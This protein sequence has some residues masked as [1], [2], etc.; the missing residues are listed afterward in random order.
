[1]NKT[2]QLD[3]KTLKEI[4]AG[5]LTNLK[6]HSKEVD[7]L[8]VFPVPDGDTGNNMSMT[9]Q[10]GINAIQDSSIVEV[11]AF[12]RSFSRGTLLG[13][14][15]NSGVILSQFMKGMM[16]GF[17]ACSMV[18]IPV[19]QKAFRMGVEKAY[20]AVINPT[21]G[22]MLTVMR[23]GCDALDEYL[24]E[25]E[26]PCFEDVF[27]K[28]NAAMEISLENTPNL[29]PV[30]KEA[31]VIDSGGAG[32]LYIFK[33]M[34]KVLK[35]EPLTF[36]DALHASGPEGHVINFSA[37]HADSVLEYG[38]CTEFILQL[39]NS[40]VD[41]RSF[42][43]KVIVDFL[44]Q[45]GDSIVAVQDEDIIKIHVHTFRPGDVLNFCQQ[46]GEF[47]TLKIENMS[48][49]HN[50]IMLK[51]EEKTTE[52]TKE[53]IKKPIAIV[54]AVS[55]SGLQ[56][57]FREIGADV[58]VDGGQTDNP[59]TEDFLEAFEQIESKTILVLPCNKN[60]VMAAEQAATLWKNADV[61]V[62]PAKT[63]AEGY[64]ALSMMNL[65]L[66]PEEV[67]RDME[68]AIADVTTGLITTCIRDVD[69]EKLS[70]KKGHF[71]GLSGD[72]V[73]SDS[74]DRL[75]AVK[76]LLQATEGIQEKVVV[77]G[78]YGSDVSETEISALEEIFQK[79]FPWLECGFIEGGQEVYDYIL[80]IE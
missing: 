17:E 47:I 66:S 77:A 52:K 22:T 24:A 8:N 34:E 73:L 3:G 32:F 16:N 42:D 18:T 2:T 13:A 63:I 79:D 39:Q 27:K 56:D 40:K 41:T 11:A 25:T 60:I 15:G 10:G 46:F 4:L 51:K 59:S 71:I 6:L 37:F 31:G 70:V 23:E 49:Q 12:A 74:E 69:Y 76:Q 58:I 35:G 36:E 44:E 80:A 20:D 5:G 75:G 14:R 1:M 78:F 33:G 43:K 30:L 26:T 21:E 9:L 48:V 29:L 50:E 53:K 28:L 68:D 38:Y 54:A 57:Y 7:E 72:S 67:I 62:I 64:S 19:F 65:S 55:G 61:C 45:E